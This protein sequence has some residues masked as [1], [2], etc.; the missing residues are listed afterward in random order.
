MSLF[1]KS[2]EYIMLTRLRYAAEL[3]TGGNYR[4]NEISYLVTFSSPSYF[5]SFQKQFGLSPSKFSKNLK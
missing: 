1:I 4:I 2:P 3:L 5:A